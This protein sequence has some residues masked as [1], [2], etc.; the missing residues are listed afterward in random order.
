MTRQVLQRLLL[1]SAPD[2]FWLYWRKEK[3]GASLRLDADDVLDLDTYF[4][5]FDETAWRRHTRLGEL[6]A[7]LR[8]TGPARVQL[9]RRAR[10]GGGSLLMAEASS[11]GDSRLT[12]PVPRP[13]HARAAGRLYIRILAG[14]APVLLKAGAWV[15]DQETSAVRLM[16][17]ICTFNRDAPLRDVVERIGNDAVVLDAISGLIIVNNGRPGL[18]GRLDVAAM[19]E[20]L[21][22][23]LHVVEQNNY[24]GA[25][26]FVRGMMTARE[27]GASHVILMDDDVV[28]EPEAILRTARLYALAER[29]FIVAGHMLDLFKP[30]RLYEAGARLVDH[31]M[32]LE[33]LHQGADLASPGAL[34]RFLEPTAMHY[35]G[36]WFM[37]LPLRLLDQHGW[38]MPCFIRGDDVEFGR[39][40]HDAGV[41]MVAMPGIGI[42]HEPF[43][44]KL[45]GWHLYYEFRNMLV[46]AS[47]HFHS[48]ARLMSVTALRWIIAELLTFRYQRAAFLIRALEDFLAGPQIYS[49]KPAETHA[50]LAAITRAYPVG[51][52]EREIVLPQPHPP[53]GPSSRAGFIVGVLR[54]LLSEWRRRDGTGRR[55]RIE[56]RDHL[57]FR[58]RRADQVTVDEP[59]ELEQPLYTR[60][61]QQFR[62]MFGRALR[63]A[64][65]LP[66][67]MPPAVQAWRKAHASFTTEAAWRTYLDI[68]GPPADN[69]SKPPGPVVAV[70]GATS[71][72]GV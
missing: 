50:S 68:T 69:T 57:W 39:R 7:E 61:R 67:S 66:R 29:D 53:K 65:S 32:T 28:L 41:A 26:G 43:Y 12:L 34:D 22:Q 48:P 24:G 58:V 44:A 2:R 46:L 45:G 36:W 18:F 71:R 47:R 25:G 15:S 52:I 30:N 23:R 31:R 70:E 40:L 72:S 19:P 11:E 14:K 60:S 9:W 55:I 10:D 33:P 59:Y 56:P 6:S 37:G 27:L 3:P 8:L 20:Q 17:V 64:R 1:R 13:A 16:P 62:T 63:L 5:S 42:W 35:N 54:A 51:S 38:P 49:R 4:N 21:R